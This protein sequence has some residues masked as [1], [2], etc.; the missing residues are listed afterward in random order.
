LCLSQVA[1]GDLTPTLT[2]APQ[3]DRASYDVHTDLAYAPGSG[4]HLLDLYVPR[5]VSGAM[6]L[7][8][9][10][11]GGG[12]QSGSKAD[13][14]QAQRLVCRGYAVASIDYRLSD[15][16]QFPAQAHDVKAAIRFLRANATTYGLD[17]SRVALFGS[18]AGGHLA[19]LAGMSGGIAELE[20]LSM[21]NASQSS[22]VQAI[23]DWY[24]PTRFT[25]MDRQLLAQGCAPGTARH[26]ASD[27]PESR[28]L[29]CTVD[30]P[31]CAAASRRADPITYVDASDPPLL[32]LHGTQDCTVPG[33][34]SMLL[35]DAVRTANVC[36]IRRSVLGANHGGP[37]WL[38]TPV[39]DAVADF[40]AVAMIR[41]EVGFEPAVNC[42]AFVV[43]GN[44]TASNG[45]TWTY[46]SVDQ[47][48][49]YALQ[50]V[51]FRPSV[52]GPT[53]AV[54]I[55]HGAGG[56]PANYSANIART[57]VGWGMTTIAVMYTHAP[58]ALDAPNEPQGAD[59][60]STAN[61]QRAHKTRNLLSCLGNVD[62]TRI[63]AHGHSMGA[64][65]TGELLGTYPTDFRAASHTAGGVSPGPNAT[66]EATARQI[67]T[68]YQLHHG[69]A[70]MVVVL[71]QDRTLDSILTSTGVTHEL[72][73]Y[74]GYSHE[75]MAAD[76]TMLE[77]VRAWY[78]TH[79]VLP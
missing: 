12:W 65:V 8:V 74:P 49:N 31:A 40:L 38:S 4:M 43:S 30:D 66:R 14:S 78:R 47:G 29:G 72:I 76:P 52:Q 10:V 54:V 37:E 51:L 61:V 64:F 28:L 21:G 68:P 17:S 32:I 41:A 46:R 27:S 70:D 50:G 71:A 6:P 75:Q 53:P 36:S 60:A 35:D 18:S 16:A 3:C 73:V 34:Q 15:E 58:D 67:R 69:D 7:V 13:V 55:S 24:G 33:A 77:R 26:G 62:M 56:T 79:G 20:D 42:Q 19:S 23:V 1:R 39:Q 45:A 57:M 48:V 44:P 5:G 25:E 22:R 63:A 59:G 2:A 9:W 11:H